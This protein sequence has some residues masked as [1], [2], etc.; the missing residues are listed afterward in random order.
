MLQQLHG[1][2][3]R[4]FVQVGDRERV[5]AIADEDLERADEQKTS[6]VHFLRFELS[7]EQAA[8]LKAGA[9]LAAG[10]DHDNYRVEIAPVPENIRMSLVGDLD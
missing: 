8:D 6:A 7:S 2:E 4:V 3:D 10:I 5:F 9:E 1:I